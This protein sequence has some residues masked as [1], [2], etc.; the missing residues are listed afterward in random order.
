MRLVYSIVWMFYII[1]FIMYVLCYDLEFPPNARSE[2][3]YTK[4]ESPMLILVDPNFVI[5]INNLF[6][7]VHSAVCIYPLHLCAGW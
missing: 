7:L 3:S 5:K 1:M 6:F 4:G 2:K